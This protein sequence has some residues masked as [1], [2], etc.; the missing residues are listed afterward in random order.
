MCLYCFSNVAGD[1]VIASGIL[2]GF[3]HFFCKQVNKR[4]FLLIANMYKLTHCRQ[5][6]KQQVLM[7]YD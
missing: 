2:C 5:Y 3:V 7:F 4:Y 1:L 6:V